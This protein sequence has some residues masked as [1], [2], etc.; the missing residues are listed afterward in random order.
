MHKGQVITPEAQLAVFFGQRVVV[1]AP[2]VA[3]ELT[4]A[5]N[6]ATAEFDMIHPPEVFEKCAPDAVIGTLGEGGDDDDDE[7]DDSPERGYTMEEVAKHNKKGNVCVV[8]NGRVLN[9]SNFLSQ[10]PGGDLATLTSAGKDATAEFGMV[11]PPDLVEKYAS[12]A[13]IGVVGKAKQMNGA[14]KSA[15]VATDKGDA[16]AN[17]EKW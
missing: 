10:H 1:G 6:D 11:H 16:V 8:L 13:I 14:G 9:V 5:G 4:F 2:L 15:P 7:E 12:D 3:A 17:V